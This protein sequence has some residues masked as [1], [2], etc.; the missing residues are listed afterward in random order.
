M[1]AK[2]KEGD[3]L[4][5]LKNSKGI[6]LTT[7]IITVVVLSIIAGTAVYT[8]IDVYKDSKEEAFVQ[9]LQ[10]IQNA[11]NNEYSKI[12]YAVNNENSETENGG[13][14]YVG[15]GED[16]KLELF[17]DGTSAKGYK[18][19]TP[20]HLK[21]QLNLNGITQTVYINFLTKDVRSKTGINGKYSLKDFKNYNI[22]PNNTDTIKNLYINT[23][24]ATNEINAH[25]NYINSI[26]NNGI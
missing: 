19:L 16:I 21:E 1:P 13:L 15:Y 12:E 22:I 23:T 3:I 2:T 11:V 24:N 17:G 20:E 18:E 25:N 6:T 8:G 10:I 7:L 5:N 4:K 14:S 9:E 26:I